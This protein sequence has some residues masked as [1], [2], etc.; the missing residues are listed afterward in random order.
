V[1]K[2]L[3]SPEQRTNH[4]EK[5][6]SHCALTYRVN[7]FLAESQSANQI[8]DFRHRFGIGTEI[9]PFGQSGAGF[10][11]IRGQSATRRKRGTRPAGV[12]TVSANIAAGR[13]HSPRSP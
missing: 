4:G 12:S 7:D 9:R 1:N 10:S 5:V 8:R 2:I 11:T 6:S 13:T 3:N